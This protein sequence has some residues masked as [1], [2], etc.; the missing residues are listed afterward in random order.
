VNHGRATSTATAGT[1]IGAIVDGSRVSVGV[2]AGAEPLELDDEPD[3]DVDEADPIVIPPVAAPTV[4]VRQAGLAPT[5]YETLLQISVLCVKFLL[6][7][8]SNS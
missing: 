4:V 8:S 6:V 3:V 5:P 7:P 2:L 1:R